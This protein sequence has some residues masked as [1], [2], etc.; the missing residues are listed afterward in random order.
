M[1]YT[2]LNVIIYMIY[3]IYLEY[4]IYYKYKKYH[5]LKINRKI[6]IISCGKII[7]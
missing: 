7:E 3:N 2:T 5:I 4:K 1:L 6:I